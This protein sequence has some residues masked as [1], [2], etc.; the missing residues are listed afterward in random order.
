MIDS[1]LFC[2]KNFLILTH[3]STICIQWQG[4]WKFFQ[5]HTNSIKVDCFLL[6]LCTPT[7][8]VFFPSEKKETPK[9]DIPQHFV[10]KLFLTTR[11]ITLISSQYIVA[12][13]FKPFLFSLQIYFNHGKLQPR[14]QNKMAEKE[15]TH[16]NSN[17]IATIKEILK[18][19]VLNFLVWS[20]YGAGKASGG[21]VATVHRLKC[22]LLK[23]SQILA[24][25][26]KLRNVQD[27]GNPWKSLQSLECYRKN[28]VIGQFFFN[29]VNNHWKKRI[30]EG[31]E[32]YSDTVFKVHS[33]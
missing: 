5:Y 20:I 4:I 29:I 21:G 18:I 15:G 12:L 10:R 16:E 26:Q 32:R 14:F 27:S 13:Y 1:S 28:K 24:K 22:P 25:F 17:K 23:G 2:W 3:Q 11:W 31:A 33:C 8:W 19:Q 30:W 6:I 9:G 7:F